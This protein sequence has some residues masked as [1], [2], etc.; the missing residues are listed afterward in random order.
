MTRQAALI[1]ELPTPVAQ[2]YELTCNES[3]SFE[4]RER[5]LISTVELSLHS[6]AI[7]LLTFGVKQ[8]RLTQATQG[9]LR[10][11]SVYGYYS[12]WLNINRSLRKVRIDSDDPVSV[13]RY[14][15]ALRK[16][17][18]QFSD[19]LVDIR[20]YRNDWAHSPI[21]P[22][23]NI[24]AIESQKSLYERLH[25]YLDS[26]VS[27]HGEGAFEVVCGNSVQTLRFKGLS[28][29]DVIGNEQ[30]DLVLYY[31]FAEYL[32][33]LH[34]FARVEQLYDGI[35]AL[36]LI[37][38]YR[39]P[40]GA[41]ASSKDRITYFTPISKNP[42][43]A[44]AGPK[45]IADHGQDLRRLLSEAC[46]PLRKPRQSWTATDFAEY[47]NESSEFRT[48]E[49]ARSYPAN[50]YFER[51]IDQK[52]SAFYAGKAKSGLLLHGTPGVGKTATT[53]HFVRKVL[54]R[55]RQSSSNREAVF[56]YSADRFSE[57]SSQADFIV[58]PKLQRV[59][60]LG[61]VHRDFYSFKHLCEWLDDQAVR[62]KIT[63]IFDGINESASS[64]KV[65]EEIAAM[66]EVATRYPNIKIIASMR[67]VFFTRN[68]SLISDAQVGT[69][70]A[71]KDYLYLDE[72]K[73]GAMR[74]AC[75]VDSLNTK[76]AQRAMFTKILSGSEDGITWE[77]LPESLQ[78]VLTTP[79]LIKLWVETGKPADARSE[80][81]IFLSYID[82]IKIKYPIAVQL[83]DTFAPTM[84]NTGSH[85]V[86]EEQLPG[87]EHLLLN[88]AEIG[89]LEV[90]HDAGRVGYQAVHDRLGEIVAAEYLLR[91]WI[92]SHRNQPISTDTTNVV[93]PDFINNDTLQAWK[94]Y[95]RTDLFLASL[96]L[97]VTRLLDSGFVNSAYCV[98]DHIDW[99]LPPLS[100]WLYTGGYIRY[101]YEIRHRLESEFH[102][103]L[104][105]KDRRNNQYALSLAL[106]RTGQLNEAI[107]AIDYARSF[108]FD[109][110][111]SVALFMYEHL[112]W[113]SKGDWNRALRCL[114][115]ANDLEN[116]LQSSELRGNILGHTATLWLDKPN[117]V[118]LSH[119]PN[120]IEIREMYERAIEMNSPEH[121]NDRRSYT[122]W[123]ICLCRFD[124]KMAKQ[125]S[126]G[127]GAR[128]IRQVIERLKSALRSGES[129]EDA[130]DDQKSKADLYLI[131]GQAT[132][133]VD[134][135]P[136]EAL[137]YLKQ[138]KEIAT[139][140]GEVSVLSEAN[141]EIAKLVG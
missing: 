54:E 28:G 97:L 115:A 69:L 40:K 25:G 44:L 132:Q 113:R 108:E 138:S 16:H 58:W 110:E 93:P 4:K 91:A 29:T 134:V 48:K 68:V 117:E 124:L 94:K 46:V 90:V 13:F 59:L 89:A 39:F 61:D 64:L 1:S 133:Q 135:R 63:F 95:P 120:N 67:T 123:T 60:G 80:I 18:E 131:L 125:G 81:S 85:I 23:V 76:E 36:Q 10:S 100:S 79:L 84:L 119:E 111:V 92:N 86:S 77:E 19:F 128:R 53:L 30:A 32:L 62:L 104:S 75:E 70:H 51:E 141:N 112:V 5:A 87:V 20:T 7:P 82:Q 114:Q 22:Q 98:L 55:S 41:E 43:R 106:I 74:L 57:S 83:A 118:A 126:H 3:N 14:K 35:P 17:C 72:A 71:V 42:E 12:G 33:N 96:T 129:V 38:S 127:Q 101:S 50:A 116:D 37:D 6:L 130:L 8:K 78:L 31:N 21:A 140:I 109:D 88:L 9:A 52:L 136:N 45:V 105:A 73:H 24:D 26:V 2:L 65:Y 121:N 56:F 47:V 27:V 139:N 15:D 102:S 99:Q 11:I 122:W 49:L 103:K 107:T 34:P 66:I 137:R